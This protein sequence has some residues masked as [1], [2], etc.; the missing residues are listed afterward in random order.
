[1]WSS[2]ACWSQEVKIFFSLLQMMWQ[3]SPVTLFSC[4]LRVLEKSW[5][6]QMMNELM[7]GRVRMNNSFRDILLE[8]SKNLIFSHTN[9]IEDMNISFR[10]KQSECIF[11]T[12]NV[13]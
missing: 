1:M 13:G 8:P 2:V 3:F 9:L 7:Q 12:E 5:K 6:I 4:D 11:K 10:L